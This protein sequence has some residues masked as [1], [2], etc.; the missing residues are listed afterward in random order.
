MDSEPGANQN[1][2]DSSFSRF[3]KLK[4]LISDLDPNLGSWMDSEF[5]IYQNH[6]DSNVGRLLKFWSAI[7]INIQKWILR[8][9]QVRIIMILISAD[10]WKFDLRSGFE[11]RNGFWTHRKSESSRFNI[12][13]IFEILMCNQ[14]KRLKMDSEP[15]RMQNDHDST[16]CRFF[17]CW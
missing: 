7:E 11:V 15:N 4:L 12:R 14:I 5:S 8:P 17:K 2:P 1:Y 10:F 13:P 6:H 9:A 16:F 3:L